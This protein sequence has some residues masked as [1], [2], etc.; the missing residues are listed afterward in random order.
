MAKRSKLSN[1]DEILRTMY[2]D[3]RTSDDDETEDKTAK[4]GGGSDDIAA[5][6][7]QIARLEGQISSA[8]SRST[9]P[10]ASRQETP[11]QAPTID[12]SKAPDPIQEPAAYAKFVRDATQATID[13]EKQAYQ[14]QQRQAS[15]KNNRTAELWNTFSESYK[16]YASNEERVEVA[17]SRVLAKAAAKGIDTDKY[18]YESSD[19]FMKDV[20]AE[21]DRLFGKPQS[22]KSGDGD[23]DDDDDDDDRSTG[24]PGGATGGT[25]GPRG[26][27]QKAP[28]SK[29]GELGSELKAWQQKVGI[30]Y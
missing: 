4:G 14:Y 28:P 17:A 6:K 12:Y 7:E 22:G 5:L 21:I 20:T 25:D 15:N 8:A 2:P 18:M 30:S 10:P 24:L 27:S 16:D 26:G 19:K 3:L 29:Y 13:Y 11:P 23:D 9:P 1:A